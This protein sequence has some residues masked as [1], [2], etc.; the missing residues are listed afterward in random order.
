MDVRSTGQYLGKEM[1]KF[2]TKYFTMGTPM[3]NLQ[4]IFVSS[5]NN[6]LWSFIFHIIAVNW[7]LNRPIFK[8]IVPNIITVPTSTKSLPCWFCYF[9]GLVS[10]AGCRARFSLPK[11]RN[12]PAVGKWLQ[13]NL[14]CCYTRSSRFHPEHTKTQSDGW[15]TRNSSHL[16]LSKHPCE[17]ML[18]W[19]GQNKLLCFHLSTRQ[20]HNHNPNLSGLYF[21]N[22][23]PQLLQN[24]FLGVYWRST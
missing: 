15:N 10:N 16:C 5:C 7:L 19:S 24:E 8:F 14:Y 20:K 6:N 2:Y 11:R 13:D 17:G 18:I 1:S 4:D 22:Q 9:M 21:P 12:T 23:S 3:S